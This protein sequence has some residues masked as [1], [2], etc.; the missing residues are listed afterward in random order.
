[1]LPPP[2]QQHQ[3]QSPPQWFWQRSFSWL[4]S[5]FRDHLLA[6]LASGPIPQH[7]AFVM[8]GNRRYARMRNQLVQE[9]HSAGFLALQRVL[10]IC[11]K[12]NI[13]CVSVY[14]FSIENFK[15]QKEEVDALMSLAEEKL[16]EISKQGA[17]LDEYGVRLNVLG[18]KELLP[19]SVQEAVRRAEDLTRHNTRAILNLC[20][21]YT[22]RDEITTAVERTIQKHQNADP[23]TII[24]EK[25]IEAN[26]MTTLGGSPPL[27]ILVRTSGVQRLSDFLLWQCCEDTQLQFSNTYWPDFGLFDFVPVILDYQRKVWWKERERQLEEVHKD[28]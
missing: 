18:R 10:E 3:Q 7:V 21:P 5:K 11:L 1:M 14:A 19:P 23:D 17:L 24:T 2:R 9:G 26:L 13:R 4:S 27:D 6:V 22:S 15:R 8:D 20:M 28:P 16:I 25:D 12:L